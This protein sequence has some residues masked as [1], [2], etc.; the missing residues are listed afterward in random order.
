M[1]IRIEE[2]E[3]EGERLMEGQWMEEARIKKRHELQY[4]YVN[5][6]VAVD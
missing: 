2:L 5:P 4:V 3:E 6:Q 1:E